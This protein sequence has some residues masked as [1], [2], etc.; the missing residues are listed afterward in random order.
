MYTVAWG[1]RR[2]IYAT[3]DHLL[4]IDNL[5]FSEEYMRIAYRDIR[6]LVTIPSYRQ[7]AV[8]IC[9]GLLLLA[10]L[11]GMLYLYATGNGVVGILCGLL[12]IPLLYIFIS[13]FV[14]GASCTCYLSTP[15]QLL[16]IP[17]PCRYGQIPAFV[18]F[19]NSRGVQLMNPS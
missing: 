9:W 15:V 2:R 14:S 19:L 10:V 4:V 7:E 16:R 6:Y 5:G 12:L 8:G 3:N 17:M 11:G 1:V 13:N 18:E